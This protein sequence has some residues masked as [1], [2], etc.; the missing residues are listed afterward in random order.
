MRATEA[1]NGNDMGA[2]EALK[3]LPWNGIDVWETFGE[4]TRVAGGVSDTSC[5]SD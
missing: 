2:V 3:L 1:L 4:E 5:V